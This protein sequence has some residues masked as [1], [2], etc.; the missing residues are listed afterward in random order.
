MNKISTIIIS[1]I[2]ILLSHTIVQA[3]QDAEARQTADLQKSFLTKITK[4]DVAIIL[5]GINPSMLGGFAKDAQMVKKFT[6]NLKDLFALA[7]QAVKEGFAESP[8]ALKE[9]KDIRSQ[10]VAVD[11]DRELNKNKTTTA[12]FALA[13][14]ER[15][16]EFYARPENQTDFDEFL[17]SKLTQARDS[18]GTSAD[19]KLT[20]EETRRVKEDFAKLRIYE[21]EAVEKSA[22][23]GAAFERKVELDVKMQQA[24]YLARLYQKKVLAAKSV[25]TDAVMRKYL[26]EN[27]TLD[28]KILKAKAHWI[29]LRAKAGEDF[30]KLAAEFTDEPGSRE[31]GGLFE[32]V[33]KGTFIAEFEKAALSLEAN[34]IYPEVVETRFGF[35]V[36]KLEKKQIEKDADG[37]EIETYNVRHILIST[38]IPDAQNLITTTLEEKIKAE[39][40]RKLIAEIR[41][42]NPIEV[43]DFELLKSAEIDLSDG[44]LLPSAIKTYL[45]R[46]FAGWKLSASK[47]GCAAE[48]NVGIVSGNFNGDEKPD[49][50]VKFAQRQK[51]YIMAFVAKKQNYKTFV[52]RD[53][54][55][56]DDLDSLNLGVMKKGETFISEEKSIV[57]KRDAPSSFRCESEAPGVHL[58]RRGKFKAL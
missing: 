57:L 10:I 15:I 4:E 28:P 37:K 42:A 7:S 8:A 24:Q 21:K 47:E 43:E 38:A 34:Q 29:F 45:D 17:K 13:T 39:T 36:I 16:K 11:Y 14:T 1:L 19:Y 50:A 32:N 2:L 6:E 54:Y 31:K 52:L 53:D 56:D 26:A 51:G 48:A 27:P 5:R 41:V 35:H 44:K 23:L 30:G 25:V 18:G 55:T 46:T 58:Y 22:S 33:K 3:Q 49:Y 9:L 20:E 12:P 40:E